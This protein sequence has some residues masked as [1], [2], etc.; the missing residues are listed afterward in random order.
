VWEEEGVSYSVGRGRRLIQ[1]G[2]RKTGSTLSYSV[3][4]GRR[5]IQ[6]GKRKTGATLMKFRKRKTG[7]TLS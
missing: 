6:C 3:G 4:R 1:C 7:A 2:K 5:L